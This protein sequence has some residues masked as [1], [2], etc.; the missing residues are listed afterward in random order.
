MQ[1]SIHKPNKTATQSG[2]ANTKD[3]ILEFPF[4]ESKE[5]EPLMGWTSSKNTQKQIKIK[6][7]SKE[8]AISFA[9]KNGLNFEVIEPNLKK[10]PL[11]SYADNFK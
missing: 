11:R 7:P 5:L 2:N 6:F 9:Q 4:D 10:V 1:V 3:W 8:S